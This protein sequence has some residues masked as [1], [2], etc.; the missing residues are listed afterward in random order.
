[1]K[2][3]NIEHDG[4]LKKV[5]AEKIQGKLWM[6]IDGQTFCFE[7][8]S[9]GA[10]GSA[11][12]VDPTI[13]KVPMPGKIMKVSCKKGDAVSKGQTLVVMEAMKMEYTLEAAADAVIEEVSCS[14][15][16][17]VNPDQVLVR[18]KV[19]DEG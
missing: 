18:L 15:D 9:T 3:L 11:N 5:K 17:Q 2:T 16:E 1:M 14:K 13:I 7:P 10:A 4:Q 19:S 12:T 6:H 8:K